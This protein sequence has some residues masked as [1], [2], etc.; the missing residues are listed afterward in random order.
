MC[1]DLVTYKQLNVS[2]SCDLSVRIITRSPA[3]CQD[4]EYH[5]IPTYPSQN[6]SGTHKYSHHLDNPDKAS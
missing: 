2:K 4:P 5:K 3:K 6:I 1:L